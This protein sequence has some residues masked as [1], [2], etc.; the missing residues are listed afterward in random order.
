ML[1]NGFGD[2]STL[3][4]SLSGFKTLSDDFPGPQRGAHRLWTDST[5]ICPELSKAH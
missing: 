5:G 1:Y 3:F 4:T 2:S